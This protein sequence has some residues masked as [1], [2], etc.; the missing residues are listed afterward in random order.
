MVDR[1]VSTVHEELF[2]PMCVCVSVYICVCVVDRCV[3][4]VHE[5]PVLASVHK[6][7]LPCI[8]ELLDST[9][10]ILDEDHQHQHQHRLITPHTC[11]HTHHDTQ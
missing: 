2:I 5:E 8:N 3:S 1:C 6:P 9:F 10:S 11:K 7:T 4:T